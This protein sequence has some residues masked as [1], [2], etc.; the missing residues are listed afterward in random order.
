[1]GLPEIRVPSNR[2]QGLSRMIQ[3]FRPYRGFQNKDLS[4]L[5]EIRGTR[6]GYGVMFRAQAL[7]A[8]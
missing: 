5:G 2:L 1:M 7:L 6:R 8:R 3:G 4:I